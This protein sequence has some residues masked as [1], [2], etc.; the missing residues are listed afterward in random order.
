MNSCIYIYSFCCVEYMCMGILNL[1]IYNIIYRLYKLVF[2]IERKYQKLC[3]YIDKGFKQE[4]RVQKIYICFLE[5]KVL[6][7]IEIKY[8]VV[9]FL[10]EMFI[11]DVE[12]S[13]FL[14]LVVNGRYV[15][16]G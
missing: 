3:D 16:V 1:F 2:L 14:K 9:F 5:N 10:Q 8:Q 15:L 6:E 11:L 12:I 7:V 4:I 13:L